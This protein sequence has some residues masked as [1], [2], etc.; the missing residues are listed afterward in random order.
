MRVSNEKK[1]FTLTEL[2]IVIG[3]M[4]I[5]GSIGMPNYFSFR[6]KSIIDGE[7]QKLMAL[8]R[9]GVGRAKSQEDGVVWAIEINNADADFYQLRS[10]G[11]T[12]TPV[13]IHYLNSVV[14]FSGATPS[15]VKTLSGGPNVQITATNTVVG[16]TS[17]NDRF[18]DTITMDTYGR[19]TR[20]SNY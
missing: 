15:V 19:V 14:E 1:G 18:T 4:A 6:Q 16:L 17:Q 2:I 20:E 11:A 12:G 13:G 7:A 9:D 3:V 8:M 10:G 5:I